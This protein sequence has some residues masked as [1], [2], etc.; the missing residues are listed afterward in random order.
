MSVALRVYQDG[1]PIAAYSEER[2]RAVFSPKNNHTE[3]RAPGQQKKCVLASIHAGLTRVTRF[4]CIEYTVMHDA[5]RAK[6]SNKYTTGDL[7][8]RESHDG[9]SLLE[10]GREVTSFEESCPS[11]LA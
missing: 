7:S 8:S 6:E 1:R 11:S 10:G 4:E 3:Y 9:A 5:R 2:P